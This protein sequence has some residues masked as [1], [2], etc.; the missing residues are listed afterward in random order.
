MNHVHR[1][2]YGDDDGSEVDQAEA[3]QQTASLAGLVISLFLVVVGLL[4][5]RELHY[6]AHIEDCLLSGSTACQVL[7]LN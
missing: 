3:N 4:L 1:L 2:W 6:Q 5:I 7:Q